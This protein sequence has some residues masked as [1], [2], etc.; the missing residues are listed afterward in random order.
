M[1]HKFYS[2]RSGSNPNLKGL[3]LKDFVGLFER[4]FDQLHQGGYF[5]E[6]FGFYCVDADYISGKVKDVE[7][8]I[9][10]SIRKKYLWPI[11]EHAKGYSEDDLFDLIEF[12]YL[13]V[14]KPIE[15]SEHTYGGCGMHWETF[16]KVE[17]QREFRDKI[18]QL[19]MHY[20]RRFE[21]SVGGEILHK[22]EAGFEPIFD[23]DVPSKDKNVVSRI[24]AATL[25]F[26]RHGASIDDR[27]QAVRDLADVL[28]KRPAV[29]PVFRFG[30]VA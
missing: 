25:K 3:P 6:A 26:R 19:L 24:D 22:P 23:A 12:L 1:V 28:G 14:S 15:G 16:N 5:D 30:F 21:L 9:L 10:L 8:E 4:I 27:R 13:Y 20:E 18:N 11:S 17:G 2:H 7:L 29:S